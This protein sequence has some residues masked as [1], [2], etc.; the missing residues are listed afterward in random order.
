[1]K[2]G[3]TIIELLI[4]ITIIGILAAVAFKGVSN[5]GKAVGRATTCIAGYTFTNSK[6][7]VQVMDENGNGIPCYGKN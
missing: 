4:V 6:P 5:K 1:M 3:F 2:N 7:P